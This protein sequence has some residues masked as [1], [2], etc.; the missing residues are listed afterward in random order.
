VKLKDDV[1]E[2]F[3]KGETIYDIAEHYNTTVQTVLEL[4]GL[5]ENPWHYD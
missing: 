2:R 3:E 4:L 1:L 5:D